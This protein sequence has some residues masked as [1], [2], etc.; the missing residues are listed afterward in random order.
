MVGSN[1]KKKKNLIVVFFFSVSLGSYEFFLLRIMI[2]MCFLF[3]YGIFFEVVY[4]F[5]SLVLLY[6]LLDKSCTILL[7]SGNHLRLKNW[8][9]FFMSDQLKKNLHIL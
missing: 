7:E 9:K 4:V 8:R 2:L 1:P 6:P 5:G 3:S